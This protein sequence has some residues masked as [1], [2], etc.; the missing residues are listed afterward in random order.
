[1]IKAFIQSI[2]AIDDSRYH[3]VMVVTDEISKKALIDIPSVSQIEDLK[4]IGRNALNNITTSDE[5]RKLSIGDE[6]DLTETVDQDELDRQ[7]F[8]RARLKVR[9]AILQLAD[10]V[11][12]TT[13]DITQ[14]QKDAKLLYKKEFLGIS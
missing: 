9:A 12:P 6:L 7:A 11:G 13:D 5:L 4:R 2:D 10:D 14:L 1:M 3:V 8:I